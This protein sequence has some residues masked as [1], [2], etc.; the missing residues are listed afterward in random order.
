MPMRFRAAWEQGNGVTDVS[1]REIDAVLHRERLDGR[2]KRLHALPM[3]IEQLPDG[4]MVAAGGESYLMAKGRPLRWSFDGYAVPIWTPVAML[5]TPPST[6]G[7]C[8]AATGGA[9][10]QCGASSM[11]SAIQRSGRPCSSTL[12]RASRNI[13]SRTICRHRCSSAS[14]GV[15]LAAFASCAA[16]STMAWQDWSCAAIFGVCRQRHLRPATPR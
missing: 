8:S 14:S 1:R 3:P 15:A 12:L 6:C 11:K 5:L 2:K 13:H 4:A 10:S 7:R 16:R 9:A